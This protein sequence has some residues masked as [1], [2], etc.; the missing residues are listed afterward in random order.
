M[1]NINYHKSPLTVVLLL[2]VGLTLG[3]GSARSQDE[4]LNDLVILET[5][6]YEVNCVSA[7][8][9]DHVTA[10]VVLV[11][12]S[13]PFIWGFELGI[14]I[15]NQVNTPLTVS[16]PVPAS[17]DD[18]PAPVPGFWD[19][20][21]SYSSPLQA[22]DYLVL[23]TLDIF[24]LDFEPLYFHL[25]ASVPSRVGGTL[26]AYLADP[27]M[28]ILPMTPFS[29]RTGAAWDFAINP[30]DGCVVPAKANSF[31]GP[32]PADTMSWGA[33]KSLYR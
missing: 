21:A 16:F 13:Y 17:L 29:S 25:T 3:A 12:P 9:L 4:L 2:I 30:V 7:A 14:A 31:C 32:L 22:A 18:P 33:V 10:Q 1:M 6:F 20:I 28:V 8:F 19:V 23:A 24:Y 27:G 15:E 26:P 5:P 11:C